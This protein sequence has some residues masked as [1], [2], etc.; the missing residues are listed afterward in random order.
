MPSFCD[1]TAPA[2]A[3]CRSSCSG[4][5]GPAAISL[6]CVKQP[7]VVTLCGSIRFAAEHLAA[8]TRLSLEGCVVLLPALPVPGEELLPADVKALAALH[9]Q[10]IAMS[11]RVHIVNPGGYVGETTASEVAYAEAVGKEVTYEHNVR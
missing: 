7:E 3:R 2:E 9:R 11:D 6:A 5:L 10:K 1:D 8:H 4:E